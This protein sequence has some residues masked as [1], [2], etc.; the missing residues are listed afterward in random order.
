VEREL[1]DGGGG[2]GGGRRAEDRGGGDVLLVVQVA[3]GGR[4]NEMR[5]G[6]SGTDG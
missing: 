3:V 1:G 5:V 6:R 4:S 2:G